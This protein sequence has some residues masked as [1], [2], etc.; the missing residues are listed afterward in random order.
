MITIIRDVAISRMQSE[1][2]R[3]PFIQQME[4]EKWDRYAKNKKKTLGKDPIPFTKI[5]LIQIKEITVKCKTIKLLED[6]EGE[7]NMPPQ[8][9]P[10]EHLFLI[11]V[12]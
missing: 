11:K 2:K 1:L 5:N 3:V 9:M 8:N 7:R 12:A 6:N 4:M 10:L